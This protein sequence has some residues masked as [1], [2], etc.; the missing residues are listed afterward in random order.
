MTQ[1]IPKADAYGGVLLT[2]EGY[3]LLREPANH[4]DGY[5]WTFAKG[6]ADPEESPEHT[7]LREVYEETGY[8]GRIIDVL[9]GVY[10]SSLS[11]TVMCVMYPLN[12]QHPYSWE[13]E[14]TRWACFERARNLISLSTNKAGRERDLQILAD[15]QAW[16]ESHPDADLPECCEYS[17]RPA[18]GRHPELKPLPAQTSTLPL[19]LVF[20][21]Q[22]S[23]L[24]RMGYVP[25][26]MEE[27]WFHYFA[28]NVMY[29][30]RSWTGI[31]VFKVYFEPHGDGLK[32][33]HVEA[34]RDPEQLGNS[35][36]EHD[37]E[38]VRA[39]LDNMASITNRL[40]MFEYQEGS[41]AGLL[42][43]T[44]PNYLGSPDVVQELFKSYFT[45]LAGIWEQPG[46]G[47]EAY[48]E[49]DKLSLI[50][51]GQN[52][53]YTSMPGWH[54]VEQ[55][56]QAL[57]KGCDLDA[58]YCDGENLYY[59]ISEA[60]AAIKMQFDLFREPYFKQVENT[61]GHTLLVRIVHQLQAYVVQLFLGTHDLSFPD[62]T[63]ADFVPPPSP[64]AP[65]QVPGY[66]VE[67]GFDVQQTGQPSE[68]D[69]EETEILYEDLLEEPDE[70]ELD[71]TQDNDQCLIEIAH[72]DDELDSQFPCSMVDEEGIDWVMDEFFE[73]LNMDLDSFF[74]DG[75]QP[76][77]I[78]QD[79]AKWLHGVCM[80]EC[81]DFHPHLW[82]SSGL[83]GH[84]IA[85]FHGI[86]K[87]P[88]T[89]IYEAG[90]MMGSEFYAYNAAKMAGAIDA[91][92]FQ[93]H[94]V[95]LTERYAK[96]FI[97]PE[98]YRDLP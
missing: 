7:A 64:S 72:E 17:W 11:S 58:D 80:G 21:A 5:H 79:R 92:Q 9:P 45:T 42:Q 67:D 56:G 66:H 75:R 32:T 39:E 51:S 73:G 37:I 61:P 31:C 63:L 44:K 95:Q 13:T 35:D 26:T 15:A 43:V 1:N 52:P 14:G 30:H 16:F 25:C 89:A 82:H 50:F 94:M 27:K 88:E 20:D 76:A 8:V 93:Q 57:V 78:I 24:L 62:K 87:T 48:Q 96:L 86:G 90:L 4:F 36:D 10:K 83:A 12:E 91:Q 47:K 40:K 49:M 84:A 34:S 97:V 59:H 68:V 18:E 71:D 38:L 6:K 54:S 33:T 41:F 77:Q 55:L 19:N 60:L 23:A 65:G 28:D 81:E 70:E 3:V 98:Q 69:S 46:T 74:G 22:Q 85:T 2:K 29:L 53:A